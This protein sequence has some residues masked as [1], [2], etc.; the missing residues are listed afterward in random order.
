MF[1][2]NYGTGAGNI[3]GIATLETAMKIADES[4]G[5]T[6][7]DIEIAKNGKTVAFREWRDEKFNPD[8]YENGEDADIID[9][10]DFGYYDE[11]TINDLLNS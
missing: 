8:F 2:I 6:R 4:A 10:G 1:D 3:A 11:W 9:Y 7:C 5:Y